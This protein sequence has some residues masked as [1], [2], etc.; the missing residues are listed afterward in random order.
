M[1]KVFTAMSVSVDGFITGRGP[2][3]GRGLGDAPRLFDW[4]FAGDVPSGV[5]DGFHL[6]RQSAQL[7]DADAERVGVSVVGRNTY[8]D[9]G[10]IGGGTPHPHAPLVLVTHRETPPNERQTVVTAASPTPSPSPARSP[11][12]RMWRSWAAAW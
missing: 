5:F 4:F 7:F 10:W 3:P 6:S 9:S 1:Q 2:G 11:A 12:T 8:D